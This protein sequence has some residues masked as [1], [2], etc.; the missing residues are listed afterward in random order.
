MMY[1][2]GISSILGWLCFMSMAARVASTVINTYF[3]QIGAS[4]YC[5]DP[6]DVI[7]YFSN[8]P[9]LNPTPKTPA[10]GYFVSLPAYGV[11]M[12]PCT[13]TREEN[14]NYPAPWALEQYNVEIGT[15]P[16]MCTKYS[17]CASGYTQQASTYVDADASC[18]LNVCPDGTYK[19]VECTNV[20]DG[21]YSR[22]WTDTVCTAWSSCEAGTYEQTAGTSTSNR[23]CVRIKS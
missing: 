18:C 8:T 19:T 6:N 2:T 23:V 14:S 15:C 11:Y 20:H 10:I 16:C 3:T 22:A 9:Y 21:I 1:A 13:A 7:T 4:G 5:Y 17:D 12:C